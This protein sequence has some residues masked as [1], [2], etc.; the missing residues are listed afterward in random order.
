M[1]KKWVLLGLAGALIVA[2]ASCGP[3]V[4]SSTA[5]STTTTL[6]AP[7]RPLQFRPGRGPSKPRP[8]AAV[9]G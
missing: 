3:E 7:P 6:P 1:L 4:E 8:T 9:T 2:P 5:A